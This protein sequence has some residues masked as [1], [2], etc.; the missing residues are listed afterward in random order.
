MYKIIYPNSNSISI[1]EP[2]P[3][4]DIN[5]VAKKDVPKGFPYKIVQSNIIPIDRTFRN[6]WEFNFDN[7]DG[8]GEGENYDNN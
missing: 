4:L 6:A 8:F 5:L 7:P 3:E 1:I 2:N